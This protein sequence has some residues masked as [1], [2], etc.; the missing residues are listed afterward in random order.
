MI[1]FIFLF[2]CNYELNLFQSSLL[3]AE[4]TFKNDNSNLFYDEITIHNRTYLFYEGTFP[5]S[6]FYNATS[7][8]DDRLEMNS[9]IIIEL[10]EIN[11]RINGIDKTIRSSFN[12][13]NL[14]PPLDSNTNTGGENNYWSIKGSDW[15][16][17]ILGFIALFASLPSLV[18]LITSHLYKPNIDILIVAPPSPNNKHN[19]H[20]E[21]DQEVKWSDLDLINIRNFTNRTFRIEVQVNTKE[22]WKDNPNASRLF[23]YNGMGKGYPFNEG[24]WVKTNFMDFAG[25]GYGVK[26]LTFPYTPEPKENIISITVNPRINLSEFGFPSFYGEIYLKSIEAIFKVVIHSGKN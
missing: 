17:L 6:H 21:H 15:I 25:G 9:D 20:Y 8:F 5:L 3:A 1:L 16:A 26:G 10:N 19:T 4:S 14:L 2:G 12:S 7:G 11:D 24:F 22:P 13:D 23:P 18:G